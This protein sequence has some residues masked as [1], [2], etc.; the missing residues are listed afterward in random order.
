MD[1]EKSYFFKC[2]RTVLNKI[3]FNFISNK[4]VETGWSYSS[5]LVI[6]Y[7]TQTEMGKKKPTSTTMLCHY[8]NIKL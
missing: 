7:V 6:I 8:K 3:Q 5:Q 1:N 2:Q 4:K